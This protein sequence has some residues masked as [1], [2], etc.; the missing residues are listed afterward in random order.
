MTLTELQEELI[1][2]LMVEVDTSTICRFLYF[3][4][5]KLSIAALQRDTFL[6]LKYAADVSIYNPNML[7][8]FG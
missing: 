3:T 2:Q 5:Q 1:L 7:I 6:R 8:F 4:R